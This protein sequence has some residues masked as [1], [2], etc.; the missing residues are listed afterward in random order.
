MALV[1]FPFPFQSRASEKKRKKENS[2]HSLPF[3]GELTLRKKKKEKRK[4]ESARLWVRLN[5]F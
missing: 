1:F 5:A 4:K 3:G 2:G